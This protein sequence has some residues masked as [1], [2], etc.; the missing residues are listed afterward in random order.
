MTSIAA[1]V[2]VVVSPL[3]AEYLVFLAVARGVREDQ[4][5]EI[6]VKLFPPTIRVKVQGKP[7]HLDKDAI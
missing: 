1:F 2:A 5:Y 6:E 7:R 3:L 4:D